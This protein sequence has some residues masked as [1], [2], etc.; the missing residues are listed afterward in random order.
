MAVPSEVFLATMFSGAGHA[1]KDSGLLMASS[2]DGVTFRNIRSSTQPIFTP[3]DGMRDPMILYWRRR[4]YL[5][6]SHGPNLSPLLFLARSADL[7][8]WTPLGSLRL[9]PDQGVG[10]GESCPRPGVANHFID[11]PQWI[12]DPAGGVHLIACIDHNHHWVELHPK[13]PDP[14]TWG[15]QANWSPVATMTGCDGQPLVQ[16]NSFVAVQNGEYHMAYNGMEST[17]YYIR[18]SRS[19]T[20]GWSTPRQLN[21]DLSMEKGD[22]ENLVCLNGGVMRFYISNGNSLTKTMW[23]V[24]SPD[25][26]RWNAPKVVT[27]EGFDAEGINWAQFVRVTDDDAIAAMAA[28]KQI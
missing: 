14:E 3:P 24:D 20:S 10:D 19:L 18:T 26:V 12:I 22:S 27:F 6:Y 25:A 21:L 23:C 2:T 8:H 17:V 1:T 9:A 4:W 11:V 13:S 28:A 7:L 15:D 16:G 5:V